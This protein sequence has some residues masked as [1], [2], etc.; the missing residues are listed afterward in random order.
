M[1]A[2]ARTLAAD[3]GAVFRDRSDVE[4]IHGLEERMFSMQQ[5]REAF[6]RDNVHLRTDGAA[7]GAAQG[8]VL[9]LPPALA[10][11]ERQ[12]ES[13]LR[14]LERALDGARLASVPKERMGLAAF[15][16]EVARSAAAEA[17][18]DA[19]EMVIVVPTMTCRSCGNR[20]ET[21]F[22]TNPKSGD[23]ICQLCGAVAMEHAIHDG[24]W[25]RN[26]EGEENTSQIGPTPDPLLSS[27]FNLR[28]A[29]AVGPGVKKEAARRYRAVQDMIEL[30]H[31][32]GPADTTER[33]TRIG[34]KDKQKQKAFERI[35][36]EGDRMKL[37]AAVL[38]RA[39]TI[40]AA[41]R[42]AH[43]KVTDFDKTVASC[44]IQAF[45]EGEF[46]S[47]LQLWR[48]IVEESSA[49]SGSGSGW[50][51]GSRR[52]ELVRR[53]KARF[54][55]DRSA[56]LSAPLK[57]LAGA[58]WPAASSD[59]AADAMMAEAARAV[60]AARQRELEQL[61]RQRQVSDRDLLKPIASMY[62]ATS[63]TSADATE[64]VERRRRE[65][66]RSLLS[67]VM[68]P[69]AAPVAA[70]ARA[71]ASGGA[72]NDNDAARPAAAAVASSSLSA[73]RTTGVGAA[74]ASG[75][76]GP[77]SAATGDDDSDDDSDDE[78]G[79]ARI[80]AMLSKKKTAPD[81]FL[82]YSHPAPPALD[83]EAAEAG[84][85]VDE[86]D[87]AALS[88]GAAFAAYFSTEALEE[89]GRRRQ[90][91]SGGINPEFFEKEGDAK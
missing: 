91:G 32:H 14:T 36:T 16:D 28:T 49:D 58:G 81:R 30:D 23:V 17:K 42:D 48:E 68:A 29:V 43:E 82:F 22:E 8:A 25:T 26:F 34:Y 78:G 46:N 6:R 90:I 38:T 1:F 56:A 54:S 7:D 73:A 83:K 66:H 15:M 41:Y 76:K 87:L 50:S 20:D 71:G 86:R 45:E 59:P 31:S 4:R 64:E 35:D 60:E 72:G 57:L 85:K 80:R 51:A 74:A 55:S 33:R 47:R 3:M 75:G 67:K 39:K 44:V 11:Q 37:S 5:Q 27:A 69:A 70:P 53:A 19:P 62:G 18:R 24:D 63:T 84:G 12:Y 10:E 9:A 61:Q 13:A 77:R 21:Q 88:S 65:A 79:D 52:L 40:F 89:Q 2:L